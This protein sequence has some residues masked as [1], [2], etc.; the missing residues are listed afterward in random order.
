MP[1]VGFIIRI[2]HDARSPERQIPKGIICDVMDWILVVENLI[3]FWLTVNSLRDGLKAKYFLTSWL[4][5]AGYEDP[6]P[7]RLFR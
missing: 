6:V 5:C 7:L 3:Y 2:F 4:H 1:L